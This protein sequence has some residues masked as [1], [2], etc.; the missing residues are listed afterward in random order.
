VRAALVTPTLWTS[1]PVPVQSFTA[2]ALL[3]KYVPK[4]LIKEI[5]LGRKVFELF[6]VV[7]SPR[8]PYSPF[9]RQQV[10]GAGIRGGGLSLVL[11]RGLPLVSRFCERRFWIHNWRCGVKGSYPLIGIAN[12]YACCPAVRR[13]GLT[14][15]RT[16]N[17]YLISDQ[18]RTL[19]KRPHLLVGQCI[20]LDGAI[21]AGVFL[22]R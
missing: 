2:S 11:L 14:A 6:A 22:C 4:I 17:G 3:A 7:R 19:T 21:S 18:R 10:I 9:D 16:V 5:I 20:A 13:D 1:H 8:L 12:V 15:A